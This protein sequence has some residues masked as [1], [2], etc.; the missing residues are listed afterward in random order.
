MICL[1]STFFNYTRGWGH[2]QPTTRYSIFPPHSEARCEP[3]LVL[4]ITLFPVATAPPSP[5]LLRLH[6]GYVS[7]S[8][9]QHITK[10]WSAYYVVHYQLLL[11]V[12]VLLTHYRSFV[13]QCLAMSSWN[14]VAPPF[15]GGCKQILEL[16]GSAA[17]SPRHPSL[18]IVRAQGSTIVYFFGMI[19][20]TWVIHSTSRKPLLCES[21][22]AWNHH[23]HARMVGWR[24]YYVAQL[25]LASVT[26]FCFT[27]D[28]WWPSI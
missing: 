20:M 10:P 3:L 16:L 1:F 5:A 18:I 12:S 25:S 8:S 7:R 26:H 21:H 19:D 11:S 14:L 13:H 17:W 2:Y 27:G 22:H 28:P 9:S 4:S 15:G 24:S 6:P 23:G